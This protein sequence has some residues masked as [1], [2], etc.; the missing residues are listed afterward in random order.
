[1]YNIPREWF[2]E[3]ED[4]KFFGRPLSDYTFEEL[5]AIAAHGWKLFQD[6]K[7][8]REAS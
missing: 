2:E 6:A 1:M 7:S 5:S 8:K 3:A 4:A